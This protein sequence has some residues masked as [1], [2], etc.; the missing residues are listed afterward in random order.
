MW[1]GDYVREKTLCLISHSERDFT[2]H[3]QE[4]LLQTRQTIANASRDMEN[5]GPSYV[6]HNLSRKQ[7]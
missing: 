6:R 2:S 3:V 5:Q 1:V 7:P 4:E